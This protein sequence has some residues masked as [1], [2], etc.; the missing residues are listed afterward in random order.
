[1]GEERIED[2]NSSGPATPL[3]IDANEHRDRQGKDHAALWIGSKGIR[4][5]GDN[6]S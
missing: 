5:T 4:G 6:D 1:M 3:Y 2:E